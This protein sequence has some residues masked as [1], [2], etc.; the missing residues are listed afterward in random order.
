MNTTEVQGRLVTASTALEGL[1]LSCS[2]RT[3]DKQ[4]CSLI[5]LAEMVARDLA[6]LANRLDLDELA[7]RRAASRA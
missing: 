6:E 5:A 3:T 4:L 2:E 1:A 7:A